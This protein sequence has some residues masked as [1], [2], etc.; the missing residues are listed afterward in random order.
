[1]NRFREQENQIR[2]Q[3]EQF[4]KFQRGQAQLRTELKGNITKVQQNVTTISAEKKILLGEIVQIQ[5]TIIIEQAWQNA[6][7][8]FQQQLPRWASQTPTD[9]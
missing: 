8:L 1:M 3:N 4:D 5:N 7:L 6:M 9:Q 2:E